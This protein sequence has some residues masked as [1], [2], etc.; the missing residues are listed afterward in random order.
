MHNR[1][2]PVWIFIPLFII[3]SID[4]YVF[5]AVKTSFSDSKPSTQ[6]VVHLVYWALSSITYIAF[7]ILVTKGY[8]EWHGW[9]KTIIIGLAQTVFIGKLFVLPFLL[10]DDLIRLL[11]VL[12]G[13]FGTTTDIQQ[14]AGISRLQFLSRIGLAIG[15]FTFGS[16]L[17]GIARGAYNYKKARIKLPI[18]NL[19]EE[20]VNLKIIQISDLH[21]GSFASAAPVE[22][23]VDLINEEKADIVFF[24]GDLVN[25]SAK[26]AIPYITILKNIKG[27]VYSILGNHDYGTYVQWDTEKELHDNFKELQDIQRHQLGWD[28]L[29][30]ENRILEKNV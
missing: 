5:Q 3:L 2:K 9:S 28:L 19:P 8:A 21:L 13:L 30:D 26:E 6:R 16:F 24:T 29:M 18:P 23:I 4:L 25:Y 20:W 14:P 12:F 1:F 7:I 10:I 15:S 22:K 11:R 27:K 17:Y